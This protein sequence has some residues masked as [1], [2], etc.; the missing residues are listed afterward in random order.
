M[1]DIAMIKPNHCPWFIPLIDAFITKFSHDMRWFCSFSV[2][3][4]RR[5]ALPGNILLYSLSME[6]GGRGPENVADSTNAVRTF[7]GK[8]FSAS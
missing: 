4:R 2:M 1:A 3:V 7:S 8:D 6:D 5:S